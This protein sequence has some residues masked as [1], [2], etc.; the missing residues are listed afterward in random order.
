MAR[1]WGGGPPDIKGTLGTLL[2]TTLIQLSSLRDAARREIESRREWIGGGD[3]ERQR[4]AVLAGL[5][6]IIV[7]LARAGELDLEDFPE[8]R[9]AIDD[10]QAL[11]DEIAA[12]APPAPSRPASIGVWRPPMDDN[13]EP[14]PADSPAAEGRPSRRR[15]GGSQIAF[16]SDELDDE[17]LAE[18][19]H[20]D[21][22]PGDGGESGS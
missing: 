13:A 21:D 1:G 3:I 8:V 11:D 20:R 22:V 9:Q 14:A 7:E 2:R 15:P 19:M 16:V 17:D 10:L 5:G 18:Y 6:A 4:T 12:A